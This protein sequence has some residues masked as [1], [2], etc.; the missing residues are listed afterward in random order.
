M[1]ESLFYTRYPEVY[2]G[3]VLKNHYTIKDVDCKHNEVLLEFVRAGKTINKWVPAR[4]LKKLTDY[5]S[6]QSLLGKTFGDWVVIEESIRTNGIIKVKI[7]NT[8]TGYQRLAPRSNVL[9]I[10]SGTEVKH[11]KTCS[12][13]VVGDYVIGKCCNTGLIF[14]VDYTDYL[15][16]KDIPFC[17]HTVKGGQPYVCYRHVGENGITENT[18]L[19]KYLNLPY[20]TR[21]IN[22]NRMDFRRSNIDTTS[23]DRCNIRNMVPGVWYEPSKLSWRAAINLQPRG[24][25]LITLK[26]S[27]DLGKC[28]QA[29]LEAEQ[30]Y[31]DGY[32]GTSHCYPW[33]QEL[34]TAWGLGHE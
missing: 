20:W 2:V 6:P 30:K 16:I 31:F 12:W 23:R 24:G 11:R 27:K 32:K 34:Y 33:R 18:S 1:T 28:I 29:R 3:A 15:K 13:K 26:T 25:K 10:L 9:K 19:I 22:G 7:E 14:Y 5:K 21:F 4:Y 17:S 8:K